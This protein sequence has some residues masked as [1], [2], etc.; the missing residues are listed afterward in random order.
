MDWA[1]QQ[2]GKINKLIF[3]KVKC[4]YYKQENFSMSRFRNLGLVDSH[5]SFDFIYLKSL[6]SIL[7]NGEG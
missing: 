3:G 1:Q 5:T 7:G 6:N 4:C 2:C